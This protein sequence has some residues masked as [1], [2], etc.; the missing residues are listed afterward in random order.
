MMTRRDTLCGAAP[1]KPQRNEGQHPDAA[2]DKAQHL[3]VVLQLCG[4][5]VELLWPDLSRDLLRL[6]QTYS[7]SGHRDTVF[8]STPSLRRG[9]GTPLHRH[10][11]MTFTCFVPS[12]YCA[13][14]LSERV[15]RA[16]S[17]SSA[18]GLCWAPRP[19]ASTVVSRPTNSLEIIAANACAKGDTS[20]SHLLSPSLA[21][22]SAQFGMRLHNSCV[23]SLFSTSNLFHLR[24]CCGRAYGCGLSRLCLASFLPSFLSVAPCLLFV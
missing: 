12:M 10:S 14:H 1:S 7:E 6:T 21:T 19:V 3:E 5:H 9:S 22:S 20:F 24:R 16:T 4:V 8:H 11:C 17:V 2:R 23:P 15:F 18:A 13:S